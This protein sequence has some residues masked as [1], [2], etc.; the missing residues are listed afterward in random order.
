MG[1][2]RSSSSGSSVRRTLR[3]ECRRLAG[4]PWRAQTPAPKR[5]GASSPGVRI[6]RTSDRRIS[7]SSLVLEQHGDALAAA[8]AEADQPELVVLAFHLGQDLGDEDRARGSDR[9]AE[10]DRT[11]VWVYLRGVELEIL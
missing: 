10:G 9:V 2:C 3:Q 4:R 8:N 11:A 1:R 6:R 7:Q 5:T